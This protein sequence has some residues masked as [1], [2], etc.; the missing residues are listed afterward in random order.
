VAEAFEVVREGF[1]E[2]ITGEISQETPMSRI[3]FAS[4]IGTMIEFYDFYIYGLAAALVFP[5]LFFPQLSPSSGLLASFATYGVAF[6]ARP[7]GGMIFGH[8]GDRVGRKAM[9]IGS[10]LTMGVSTFLVGLLP[11]Y[12]AIGIFAPILLVILRFLQGIGLGG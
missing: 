12:A 3:A 8:F 1:V 6:L 2:K 7:L 9:L 5:A 10:L 11:G 4:F